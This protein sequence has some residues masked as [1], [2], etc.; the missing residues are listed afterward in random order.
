MIAA[1]ELG[2]QDVILDDL[3]AR[4]LAE[5][6]LLQPV[7]TLGMLLLAKEENVLSEIKPYLV[8]F[9]L[10]SNTPAYVLVLQVPR[11]SPLHTV[12]TDLTQIGSN[13]FFNNV[14][15]V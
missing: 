4:K 6:F 5:T 7:G 1:K 13:F 10:V 3:S 2:I 8:I 9:G 14:I 15:V 12:N 11:I